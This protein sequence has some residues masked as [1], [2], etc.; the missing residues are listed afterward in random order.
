MTGPTARPA[1]GAA[2]SFP[3]ELASVRAAR[4][5]L[6]RWLDGA[7]GLEPALDSAELALSE[8]ASNAV[9]HAH[10]PFDVRLLPLDGGL[11]VEVTDRWPGLPA[12]KRHGQQA[13]TGR[14]LELVLAVAQEFG[15]EPHGPDGKTV[16]FEVRV[17]DRAAADAGRSASELLAAWDGEA[18]PGAAAAPPDR[19]VT[20]DH[21]GAF[22]LAGLPL[23]LWLTAREHHD[24]VLRDL[25]LHAAEH[26]AQAPTPGRLALADRA[27]AWVSVR[28]THQVQERTGTVPASAAAA[29][30]LVGDVTVLVGEGAVEAFRTL[31]EVLD[32]A[33]RLAEAEL[34]LAPPGSPTVVAVRRWAC[35][36]AL[37]QLGGGPG[38]PW[39][40]P[41]P[42]PGCG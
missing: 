30:G 22:V 14:G 12:V 28:V 17:E 16:W 19:Q 3:S 35:A 21:V 9:L 32:A 25:A 36:Q 24:A 31:D 18:Q 2:A 20:P 10:T 29:R 34:L 41:A 7:P 38:T 39:A 1:R 42:G 4:R 37:T 6:R 13:P 8:V 23:D 33:E 27:R 15:V 11:R 40:P 5:F 26:P